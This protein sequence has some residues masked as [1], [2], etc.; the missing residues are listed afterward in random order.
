MLET[1]RGWGLGVVGVLTK[2]MTMKKMKN[3]KTSGVWWS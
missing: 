1:E 3:N 2:T